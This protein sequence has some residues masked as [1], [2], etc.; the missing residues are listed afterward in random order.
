MSFN[1]LKCQCW[2]LNGMSGGFPPATGASK[3]Y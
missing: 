3:Q 2:D 1:I